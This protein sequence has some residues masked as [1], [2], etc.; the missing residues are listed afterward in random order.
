MISEDQNKM[1][2]EVDK[3]ADI[4]NTSNDTDIGNIHETE[5]DKVFEME[6]TE[7]AN[8]MPPTKTTDMDLV[9]KDRGWAWMCMLGCML[10]NMLTVGG[11]IKTFG[12]LYVAFMER[13]DS[14]AGSAAWIVVIAN[15]ILCAGGSFTNALAMHL[16]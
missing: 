10:Q 13:F 14:Q 8:E 16:G 9:P 5:I 15:F 7:N 6:C 1:T 3:P 11:V 2:M 12:I 4:N